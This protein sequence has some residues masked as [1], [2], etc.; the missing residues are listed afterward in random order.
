LF[1]PFDSITN[2]LSKLPTDRR[3]SI[4]LY[5]MSGR[6]SEIAAE[7]LSEI[8]YS[9]VSQVAGGMIDWRGDGRDILNSRVTP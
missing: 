2:D 1:V 3:A 4:V 6:M 7:A 9:N 5:C 8:G